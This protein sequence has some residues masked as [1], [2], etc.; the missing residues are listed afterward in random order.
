MAASG[1]RIALI[2]T[3][4]ISDWHVRAARAVGLDVVAVASRPGSA[5]AK[6][7]ADRHGIRRL[8]NGWRALLDARDG[9]DALVIATH[10]DG[11]PEVLA[12]GM[13]LG[14]PILVEKPV[15]WSAGRL[16]ALAA[17]AHEKVIVGFNRRY[18]RTVRFLRDEVAAGPPVLAH[19]SLPESVDWD[20]T[21]PYW[22]PFVS[23]SS[24]GLDLV[25]FVF[26]EMRVVSV[27]RMRRPGGA[28]AAFTATLVSARGDVV[29]LAGNWNAAANFAL[30]VDRPGRRVE[31]RPFELATVY[32]GMEVV[33]PSP[34]TPIRRY[35]P[36]VKERVTLDETDRREKPGFV[37][38]A[39]GLLALVHGRPAPAEAAT[40]S[41]AAAAVALCEEIVGDPVETR[42]G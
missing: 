4:P 20:G 3:G 17:G 24:H 37:G 38:Q 42:R 5:R 36:R 11:T 26:G 1:G 19:L 14:V 33:E 12:A 31:L 7:F 2:G 22:E 39:V 6:D 15:A 40:L 8:F 32:E 23:N 21:R 9:W 10:T 34:E 13:E 30:T 29:Q 35:L 28:L 41:D 18:Y 27:H 16:A 25:R